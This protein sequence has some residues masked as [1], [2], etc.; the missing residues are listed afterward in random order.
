MRSLSRLFSII[1]L[2]L[3][4]A[5]CGVGK[6][7]QTSVGLKIFTSSLISNPQYVNGGIVLVGRK[8]DGLDH[9]VM[10]LNSGDEFIDLAQGPWEFVVLG[11]EDTTSNG[12]KMNG[13]T[14]CD[15]QIANL[16]TSQMTLNFTLNSARCAIALGAQGNIARDFLTSPLGNISKLKFNFCE[17]INLSA[18]AFSTCTNPTTAQL[19]SFKVHYLGDRKGVVNGKLYSSLCY[20]ISSAASTAAVM[21]TSLNLPSAVGPGFNL[22]KIQI[23][24]FSG[25]GC[26]PGNFADQ[27]TL[28][29]GFRDT[30]PDATNL[31]KFTYGSFTSPYTY[32]YLK[33][34]NV[35]A[36]LT[37]SLSISPSPTYTFSSTVIGSNVSQSFT[38]TNIGS[39]NATTISLASFTGPFSQLSS[40]CGSTITVGANCVYNISFNP[41]STSLQSDILQLNYHNGVSNQSAT[42]SIDGTGVNAAMINVSGGASYNFGNVTMSGAFNTFTL[43]NSGGVAATSMS[44]ILSFPYAYQGGSYPGSGG[45]CTS[46]LSGGGATCTVNV[47]FSPN[48]NGPYTDTMMINY[49]NG[50]TSATANVAL[51][52]RALPDPVFLS[53]SAG[54]TGVININW[55]FGGT[56]ASTNNIYLIRYSDA[57][58]TAS[59]A[60]LATTAI[61]ATTISET[62]LPSGTAYYYKATVKD[63]DGIASVTP[64]NCVGMVA[65]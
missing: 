31:A 59:M 4:A 28:I 34:P 56:Q 32:I 33:V 22:G 9:F 29:N 24:Y 41:A 2:L 42:V 40:T 62:G 17:N 6:K 46:T 13:T 23:E 7:A 51:Q 12:L 63:T 38:V 58:C 64:T 30:V 55:P 21:A 1:C 45:T 44:S 57:A 25:A 52:A 36:P 19:F 11:W 3:F 37:A 16:N 60:S 39:A 14:R 53:V 43:T 5:A 47:V 20:D 49:L 10:G 8:V 26:S 61:T 15:Y 27:Q 35:T 48:L 54:G 65:P 50:G 18:G